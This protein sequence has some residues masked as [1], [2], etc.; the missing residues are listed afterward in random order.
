MSTTYQTQISTRTI[1][2]INQ[3]NTIGT[4]SRAGNAYPDLTHVIFFFRLR[5]T[6]CL[7]FFDFFS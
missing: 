7:V 6:Q 5:I 4:T 1:S 2:Y 3:A